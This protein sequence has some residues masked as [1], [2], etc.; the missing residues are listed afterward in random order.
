MSMAASAR[1]DRAEAL[2]TRHG[3]ADQFKTEKDGRGRRVARVTGC[4]SSA[5]SKC[6]PFRDCVIHGRRK[7]AAGFTGPSGRGTCLARAA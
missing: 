4:L 6:R 5:R 3:Q 7:Q 2:R 1:S